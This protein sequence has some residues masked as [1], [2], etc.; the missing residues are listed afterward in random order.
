MNIKDSLQ[1][2]TFFPHLVPTRPKI[3]FTIR[4]KVNTVTPKTDQHPFS[5][6]NFIPQSNIKVIRIVEKITTLGSS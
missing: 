5:A 3:K 2:F 6:N 4:L 1:N